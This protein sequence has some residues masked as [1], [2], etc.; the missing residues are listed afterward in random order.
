MGNSNSTPIPPGQHLNDTS[1]CKVLK[2]QNF[3]L[4]EGTTLEE[5]LL[6]SSGKSDKFGKIQKKLHCLLGNGRNVTLTIPET[7][8]ELL[9]RNYPELVEFQGDTQEKKMVIFVPEWYLT[10]AVK[11]VEPTRGKQLEKYSE[12]AEAEAECPERKK[13][14]EDL[15]K[16]HIGNYINS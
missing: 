5:K 3:K 9:I 7:A 14:F 4:I 2:K 11:Y 10:K 15:R 12:V 8:N 16:F 6:D 1:F 13:Y